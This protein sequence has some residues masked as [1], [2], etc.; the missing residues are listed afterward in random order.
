MGWEIY[1]TQFGCSTFFSG[2]QLRQ[3]FMVGTQLDFI[4]EK[5]FWKETE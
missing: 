2:T 3:K 5:D 4:A 1:G